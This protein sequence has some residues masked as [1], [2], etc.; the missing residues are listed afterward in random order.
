MK[1]S[2]I[3]RNSENFNNN[4]KYPFISNKS[5]I[6]K[7]RRMSARGNNLFLPLFNRKKNQETKNN[8]KDKDIL[9]PNS[10]FKTITINNK[11]KE[12]T[13]KH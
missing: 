13:K 9:N 12:K 10:N 8:D 2:N 11:I 6:N 5:I 4:P 1:K 7:N 3:I